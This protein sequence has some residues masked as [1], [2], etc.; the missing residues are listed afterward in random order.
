MTIP[1]ERKF[2]RAMNRMTGLGVKE[3]RDRFLSLPP[4]KRP[5]SF[6]KSLLEKV[7]ASARVCACVRV[8]ACA[9]V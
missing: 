3:L 6:M 9:R 2:A 7:C 1:L 8:R 5:D 4:E